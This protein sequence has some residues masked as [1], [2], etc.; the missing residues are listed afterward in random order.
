MRFLNSC[1]TFSLATSKAISYEDMYDSYTS[2]TLPDVLI[3]RPAGPLVLNISSIFV[4]TF[5]AFHSAVD[6]FGEF[7]GVLD[8]GKVV[9]SGAVGFGDYVVVVGFLIEPSRYPVAPLSSAIIRMLSFH[10]AQL[11]PSNFSE[12]ARIIGGVV[13]VVDISVVFCGILCAVFQKKAGP[14]NLI[15]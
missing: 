4:H 1:S 3:P 7:H 2:A 13:P 8:C 14:Y 6:R 5:L 10:K 11:V 12:S 9:G 15:K